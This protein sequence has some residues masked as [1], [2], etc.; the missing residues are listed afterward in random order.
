MAGD[1][2]G[3]L[4]KYLDDYANGDSEALNRVFEL[5]YEELRE[6]ARR[7]TSWR[8]DHTLQPTALVHDAYISLLTAK[9]FA[10]NLA[11]KHRRY[12]FGAATKAMLQ[13]LAERYRKPKSEKVDVIDNALADL[14][15]T[16][17]LDIMDLHDAL[18]RL[19]KLDSRKHE[20]VMLRFF[21]GLTMQEIADALEVSLSTVEKDWHF[22]RAWLKR[23]LEAGK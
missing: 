10:K 4:T 23:Q 15:Q 8:K 1:T 14:Q 5:V 2:R 19:E 6:I 17:R 7:L 11:G 13:L 21:A 22:A 9:N 12:F 3:Q 20:V 18:Q 16:Q